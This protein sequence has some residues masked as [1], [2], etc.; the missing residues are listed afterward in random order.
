M[1]TLEN[2]AIN[3]YSNGDLY[4]LEEYYWDYSDEIK[5]PPGLGTPGFAL[6]TSCWTLC[7]VLY[8]LLT[9]DSAS[10]RKK[11]PIGRF[12]SHELA[13]A[14]D[15][16]SAVFWFSGF[17]ALALYSQTLHCGYIGKSACG[18]TITSIVV[19]LCAWYGDILSFER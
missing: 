16:L 10:T 1:L 17:I 6:F 8:L 12:F 9:S 2:A 5:G 7:F 15:F 13:F 19:G 14:F 18:T 3:W 4:E 11:W